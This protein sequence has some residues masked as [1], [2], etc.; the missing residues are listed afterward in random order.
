MIVECIF[1][2]SDEHRV[3]V[4]QLV[5]R[6]ADYIFSFKEKDCIMTIQNLNSDKLTELINTVVNTLGGSITIDRIRR[7]Y[8]MGVEQ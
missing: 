8:M 4:G 3:M 7:P 5:N 2:N 1:P 6:S